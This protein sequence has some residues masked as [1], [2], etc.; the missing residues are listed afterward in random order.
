MITKPVQDFVDYGVFPM[1]FSKAVKSALLRL[2]NHNDDESLL[3]LEQWAV[4]NFGAVTETRAKE[5]FKEM[6]F[7]DE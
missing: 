3:L 5:L 4:L 7:K 6:V 1:D 2:R